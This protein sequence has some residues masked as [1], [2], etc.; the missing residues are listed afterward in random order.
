M[1]VPAI[2]HIDIGELLNDYIHFE[3]CT[4]VRI[5]TCVV[6]S[7]VASASSLFSLGEG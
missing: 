4:E 7:P 5:L 3:E 6:V 2:Y 1:V